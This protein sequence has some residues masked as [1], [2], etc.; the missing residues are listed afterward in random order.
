MILSERATQVRTSAS[1][2]VTAKAEKM[3]MSGYNVINLG[4]GEV[5]IKTPAHITAAA[6]D[7]IEHNLPKYTAVEGI[8]ELREAVCKKMY[9]DRGLVYEPENVVI[10]N[11]A[12]QA[13]MNTIFSV[14]GQSDEVIISAPYW[15]SYVEVVLLAGG[16]PVIVYT[17][18]EHGYKITAEELEK[19]YTDK[20]KAIIINSPNNPTG[21]LYTEKELQVIAD[22]AVEKDLIVISDEVYD[23]MIYSQKVKFL[24]IASLGEE[25]KKR[26]VIVNSLSKTYSMTP[27]RIGYSIADK[28]ISKAMTR[29]QSHC[30]SNVNV[31]SQYAA[32]AALK[33][34]DECID[35]LVNE[36][37]RRRDYMSQR[38]SDIPYLRSIRPV[39]GLY[40]LV[41]V[42]RLYG[43]EVGGITI[44]SGKDVAQILLS[45]YN[46]AV[47]SGDVFGCEDYI[48]LSFAASMESIIVGVNRIEK[49][50]K[51][52]F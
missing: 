2:K 9:A 51:Q 30:T 12:K 14:V 19:V 21:A 15:Q 47:V 41:N 10:T 27:W 4:T 11:G 18:G 26:T 5:D 42:L 24:S 39:G 33:G 35:R 28:N 6:V 25:I 44:K 7:A 20:T 48:R 52:N 34:S 32:L 17:R 31:V 40:I 13:L 43:Q 16:V 8:A 45:N 36:L 49:F 22:F 50:I 1:L 38:I 23:K 29:I 37:K 46:V 3:N